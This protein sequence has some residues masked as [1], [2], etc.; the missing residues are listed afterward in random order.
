M[1]LSLLSFYHNFVD[2][3]KDLR[4]AFEVVKIWL[5]KCSCLFRA[6]FIDFCLDICY[7]IC[8]DTYFADSCFIGIFWFYFWNENCCM[9]LVHWND[10][11]DFIRWSCC[12][13][14]IWKEFQVLFYNWHFFMLLILLWFYLFWQLIFIWEKLFLII[15]VALMVLKK[16]FDF[17]ATFVQQW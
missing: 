10:F 4:F 2:N 9:A 6:I 14:W 12:Y 13:F 5:F 1:T 17:F 7:H 11:W 3:F 8:F 16:P 15:R